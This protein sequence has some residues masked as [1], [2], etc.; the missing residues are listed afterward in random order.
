VKIFIQQITII[1]SVHGQFLQFGVNTTNNRAN[2]NLHKAV[3]VQQS[4]LAVQFL[5]VDFF[6]N[7]SI[8]KTKDP[9]LELLVCL[10]LSGDQSF[11][12][13]KGELEMQK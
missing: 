11:G 10:L 2:S 8:P 6:V 5:Q 9:G 3:P 4:K 13:N 12:G 1:A 7:V